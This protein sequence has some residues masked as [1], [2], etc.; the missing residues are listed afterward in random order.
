MKLYVKHTQF[1]TA[2]S[3]VVMLILFIN[4]SSF[5]Q[6]K[7]VVQEGI[8]KLDPFAFNGQINTVTVKKGKTAQVYLA[9]YKGRKY[10]IQ[11]HTEPLFIGKV[12]FKIFDEKNNEIFNSATSGNTDSFIFYSNSAQQFKV[13]VYTTEVPKHCVTVLIGTEVPKDNNSVRYL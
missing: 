8:N 4:I 12:S 2:F 1:F 7:S 9:F 5:A 3:L 11:V 13:E 6:C 10:K